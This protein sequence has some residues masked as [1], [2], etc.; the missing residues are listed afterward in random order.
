M[1]VVALSGSG[2]RDCW[3][4]ALV[5]PDGSAALGWCM[6]VA[7]GDFHLLW[8]LMAGGS[9]LCV[10][11]IAGV[12]RSSWGAA[13]VHGSNW[14]IAGVCRSSW[15]SGSAASVLPGVVAGAA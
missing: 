2:S 14:V 10:V 13:G 4:M 12:R 8:V 6:A 11:G 1:A 5:G 7:V 9:C 3:L 15:G